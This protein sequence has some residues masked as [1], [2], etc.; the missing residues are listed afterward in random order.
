MLTQSGIVSALIMVGW[1]ECVA[2]KLK[3]GGAK[4]YS[5]M[6]LVRC[7]DYYLVLSDGNDF[8]FCPGKSDGR[9]H[10][11]VRETPAVHRGF[12]IHDVAINPPI[13]FLFAD[14]DLIASVRQFQ[15]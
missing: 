9:I 10:A 5:P 7:R 14:G 11:L 4:F 6:L 12:Q 2:L 3:S 1:V 13:R 8:V 15:V